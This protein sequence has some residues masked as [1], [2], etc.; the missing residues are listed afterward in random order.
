MSGRYNMTHEN[1]SYRIYAQVAFSESGKTCRT[2]EERS[3]QRKNS[4]GSYAQKCL[5][6]RAFKKPGSQGENVGPSRAVV[7]QARNQ[8]I[9]S[10][11]LQRKEC[12]TS[13]VYA[14]SEGEKSVQ[15]HGNGIQSF[16]GMGYIDVDWPLRS[17][18][19]AA[20]NGDWETR[21]SI[22]LSGSN[23]F[24]KRIYSG[25]LPLHLLG[26]KPVQGRRY[27]LGYYDGGEGYAG[28]IG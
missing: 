17:E 20:V 6:A 4:G 28:A 8:R 24:F 9:L 21:N 7:Q 10:A 5:Q 22:S 12:R 18:R 11:V 27:G 15:S 16:S 13:V 26:N 3:A 19:I 2:A 1:V 14:N 25:K 23:R